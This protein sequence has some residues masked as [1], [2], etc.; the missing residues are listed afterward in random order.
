MRKR[1]S[2]QPLISALSSSSLFHNY[3]VRAHYNGGSK[4]D[5]GYPGTRSI[6]KV[7]RGL[8]FPKS[9]TNL[10]N[11]RHVPIYFVIVFREFTV[12]CRL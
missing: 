7:S 12:G 9:L 8:D 11:F 4:Q 10:W 5:Y 3:R 2:S 1:D 6:A